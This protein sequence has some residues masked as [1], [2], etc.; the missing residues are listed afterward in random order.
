MSFFPER[1]CPDRQAL[2]AFH[3]GKL[4]EAELEAIAAHLATCAACSTLLDSL[5][6]QGSDSLLGQ[7]Q[8]CRDSNTL[9][10]ESGCARLEAAALALL[11]P[12]PGD[13]T[14]DNPDNPTQG[15]PAT[16]SA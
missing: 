10:N 12:G 3:Q 2:E 16:D 8:Q 1:A 15:G 6:H 4:A 13:V 9:L 5:Q 11:L 7:L 14:V